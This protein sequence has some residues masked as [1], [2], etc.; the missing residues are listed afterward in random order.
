VF[1]TVFTLTL[2]TN[3]IN[4]S[5]VFPSYR[6]FLVVVFGNS[7]HLYEKEWNFIKVSPLDVVFHIFAVRFLQY[8]ATET[9]ERCVH[10]CEVSGAEEGYNTLGF[11]ICYEMLLV[12]GVFPWLYASL[13]SVLPFQPF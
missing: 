13:W 2:F 11:P 1:T 6:K 7:W 12:V 9:C 8:C 10:I 5:V 3:V 4:L